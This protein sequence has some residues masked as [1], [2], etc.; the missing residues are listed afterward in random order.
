MNACRG[1]ALLAA[2]LLAG[3][4]P[5]EKDPYADKPYWYKPGHP[6]EPAEAS[7]VKVPDGFVAERVLTVPK[8]MGSWTALA[9]D[10]QGRLVAASQHDPGLYRVTPARIGDPS[11]ETKVE[12]LRGTAEKIGWSHGLLFAF[13][14]LYVTVAEDGPVRKG[15]HRLKDS[16]GDDRYDTMDLVLPL[17]GGGEHGPHNLVVSP[18][19]KS[20]TLIAGNG[21]RP[22]EPLAR[23]RA[24]RTEGVDHLM[25][26]GFDT[27][28]HS[29]EGWACRFDPEGG[30]RELIC[31]GLRN[32]FDL[33]YDRH[34]E[35]FT[36]DSDMEWDLGA[37]WYRPTRVCQLVSGGEFGWRKGTG[38]WPD[39][40][41]DSV[42]PVVNVGPSSPTGLTFGYGAKFP[43]RY[44][45][46]LFVC[47]WTF[48]TIHAVHLRP[49][50][51]GWTATLEE[52]AAGRGLPVTDAVVGGDGALYFAVGGRRLGSAVYRVRYTGPE[53]TAPAEVVDDPAVAELRAL[54][55]RLEDFHGRR[56]EG[57][58]AA[59]WPHLGH[60]DRAVRFAA[61]LALEHQP[62][63]SWK[64]K[65]LGETGLEARL[66]ALLALARQGEEP[67]QRAVVEA[68]G[69]ID[70]ARCS[71]AQKL[72]VLRALELA[73]ARG[74]SGT[75]ALAPSTAARLGKSFPDPDGLV[76]RE[77]ARLLC[78]LGAPDVV[79]RLLAMMEA[80]AGQPETL[81]KGT[82]AR[83]DKYGQA[84]ADM[85]DSA[86][87][88]HRMHL[89]QMLIWVREGWTDDLR[90]RYFQLIADGLAHS[91][92]GYWYRDFWER[93]RKHALEA[94]PAGLR[95]RLEGIRS[96][97]KKEIDPKALPRAK[98]PG[99]EWTTDAVLAE[100]KEGLKGRDF[101]NGRTMFAAASCVVC[102]RVRDEGGTVG[103]RLMGLGGRF[104]L[105]DI[106]EAV[107]DPNKAVSDQYRMVQIRKTDG[108]VVAGR[109][110]FLES[111]TYHLMPDMLYPGRTVTVR[112]SEIG[113]VKA[114]E[115]SPMPTR[116]LD[117]LS[118][119]EVLDL[120]AYLLSE[121]DPEH[122]AFRR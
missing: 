103:P 28:R 52:F 9:V 116:L 6:L 85:L 117:P 90:A 97:A 10:P 2:L 61:R 87:M 122:A 21:T 4:R 113:Q 66:T 119:D 75:R 47:D 34:G 1:A 86:P 100:L 91:K 14:S 55:R 36:F 7:A 12:R 16:D 94:V 26:P 13:D 39:Y 121:G 69:S 77:L 74:G 11:S 108:A 46:A 71:A 19:G 84:V 65:A 38:I 107:V 41:P 73:F 81:G 88:V 8:A 37:P 106:V 33:A 115:T 93:T 51:A 64:E 89:A 78:H 96:A 29:V 79:G 112:A 48:A 109:V 67:D 18:D 5:Q 23:N 92:G 31:S 110:S 27:T 58:V 70:F 68:L 50:G 35:L 105:R 25:P 101:A 114:V 76:S 20:L 104:T 56:D 30:N 60:A 98:G 120:M 62:A 43:A 49:D 32:S 82:F 59:A 57:A 118:R 95:E 72:S 44:Q 83:N 3:A 54:R 42:A 111:G 24:V 102:H 22:P 63:A 80:D 53:S 99:R 40:Y 17:Q 45:R 15:V